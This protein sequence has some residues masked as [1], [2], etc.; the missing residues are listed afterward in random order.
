M[1][2]TWSALSYFFISFLVVTY[3]LLWYKSATILGLISDIITQYVVHD[4]WI[5]LHFALK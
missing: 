3:V 2:I 5:N 4:A 1:Q